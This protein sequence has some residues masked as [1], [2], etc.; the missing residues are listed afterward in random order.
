ME[1]RKEHTPNNYLE[2]FAL[3]VAVA[4][5]FFLKSYSYLL[6]HCMAEVFSVAIAGGIFMLAWSARRSIDN[7]SLLL[8][9]AAYLFIGFLDLLHMLVYT[10]MGVAKNENTD[11]P[12]QLWIVAR[13]IESVSLFL[14]PFFFRR[15]ISL[16]G[17]IA[18]YS[19]ITG[20]LMLSIFYWGNFPACFIDG[21]GLTSFKIYSE[22]LICLILAGSIFTINRKKEGLS[23]SVRWFILLSVVI[24]IGSELL[25]TLYSG[26]FDL[27]NSLGHILKIIS[28]Y[29]IYRALVTTAVVEPSKLLFRNLALTA[30]A[31]R[32]ER[33]RLYAILDSMADGVSIINENHHLEYVN[34]SMEREFGNFD[35]HVECYKYIKK[36]TTPCDHCKLKDVIGGENVRHNINGSNGKI[37]DVL[38]TPLYNI[39]GTVSKLKILRDITDRKEAEEALRKSEARLKQHSKELEFANQELE[40]F[41]YSAS[42][43][44]RAP[45]RAIMGFSEFLREDYGEKLDETAKDYIEHICSAGTRMDQLIDDLLALSRISRHQ[46]NVT[47]TNLSVIAQEFAVELGG[48]EPGRNVTFQ[49]KQ[50]MYHR[51]D[52]SLLC[53][54]ITNLLRN[55]WKYSSYKKSAHIEFGRNE[56][57]GES[58]YYIN[59]NGA[60]FNNQLT[61]KLFQPFSRLHSDAEFKG[62]GI[63]LAIVKRIIER[64]GGRVWAEGEIEVGATF[65]FAL[66]TDL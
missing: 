58:V 23:K 15:R 4:L 24:T 35:I 2:F 29:L 31:F 9:G 6:F 40:S 43:D 5:F 59:D 20:L 45:L 17:V 44:L 37:Y 21:S 27:Y 62:T 1:E 65:Y 54:V 53:Q 11:L 47:E 39:D 50:S 55:A 33:D 56:F 14:A 32:T 36:R 13:F 16:G 49:I 63:G 3:S 57:G 30:Q 42:H 10:G 66:P 52:C 34:P 48:S 7:G 25:F 12:T 22:Y 41:S 26:P 64:H 46:L 18:G 28:F 60:G 19:I 38:E 51:V 61:D 8:L